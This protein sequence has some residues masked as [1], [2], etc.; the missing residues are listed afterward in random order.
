MKLD[1]TSFTREHT[2][3]EDKAAGIKTKTAED[4]WN[5]KR[6]NNDELTIL[7]VGLVRAAGLKAYVASVANR[8]VA[9]FIP[10]YLSMSQL[11]DDIAIVELDGKDEYFDP[12]E[13]YCAF[14]E[15]HWKHS[16]TQGLRQTENGTAI[17]Q[18][19][20]PVYKSTSLLRNADIQVEP[21]GKVHGTLRITMTGAEAL[22]WRQRLL[23]TDENQIKTEF[24]NY[25]QMDIPAGVQVKIHHFISLTEYDKPL[26]AVLDFTG[27]MGT[28]T[29]K[30]V[31]LPMMFFEASAKP[32][33]VHDKRLVP[34]DLNYPYGAKDVVVLHLPPSFAVESTPKNLA[35]PLPKNAA[36]ETT[37][38]QDSGKL[39]ATRVFILANTIYTVDEYPV[40]KISFRR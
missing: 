35:I 30:R 16:M 27:A 13:R 4:I 17:A 11:D 8:D 38:K 39:E 32:L 20:M 24:A 14:N 15:L 6:G 12:G 37:F 22:A 1:N 5:A 25:I 36:Y 31:F 3:A 2:G 26:M 7:F 10:A 19:P 21:D 28:A 18:T 9:F 33:F 23:S 29:S 40:S 34:V